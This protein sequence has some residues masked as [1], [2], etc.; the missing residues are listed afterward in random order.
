M[1]RFPATSGRAD[2]GQRDDN[3]FDF[4]RLFAASA[5]VIGHSTHYLR[6]S[7]LWF[8]P[9]SRLWFRDGVALFFVM[10]G[11]LIYRSAERCIDEG[12][13]LHQ[14]YANR[15]LRIVPAIY[16]YLLVTAVLLVAVG[17]VG[18]GEI[19]D[20]SFVGWFVATAA[21][22]P[23]Y[24]PDAWRD[25]ATGVVNGAL[26]TIPVEV[27]FYAVVPFLALAA[28]RFGFKLMSSILLV[29]ALGG[30]TLA[31]LLNV[32]HSEELVSELVGV[33][34]LPYLFYFTLGIL[35]SKYWTRLPHGGRVAAACAVLYFVSRAL[36]PGFNERGGFLAYAGTL[37]WAL[38]FSYLAVWIGNFGPKVLGRFTRRIGDLSFGTYIWHMV[39]INAFLLYGVDE[40][41]DFL[42]NPLIHL[43]VLGVSLALA[44]VSW[45]LVERPALRLKPFTSHVP[46]G[47]SR[48]APAVGPAV[49]PAVRA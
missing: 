36:L 35:L 4:L 40:S 3:C 6:I 49:E 28:R 47:E 20:K 44:S 46:A 39:V 32:P 48:P 10:S 22:V 27:A 43:M 23:V 25:T 2:V 19:L 1:S 29:V 24:N 41:F 34:F 26:W 8:E 13:P 5:V 38:P 31:W 21:L 12:R 45:R 18:S 7:F 9:D 30:L 33:T 16:A 11:L 15:L 14:F 17:V 42:P 37:I